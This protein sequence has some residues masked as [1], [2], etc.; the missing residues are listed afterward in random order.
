MA[1]LQKFTKN[2]VS[3]LLRHFDRTAN[4]ISNPDVNKKLTELNYNCAENQTLP[5][6]EFLQKRL[7]QVKI[8]NRKDVNLLCDWCLTA[9]QKLKENE[10]DIF[11]KKSYEFLENRYG[12][13]NVVSAWVHLDETTPHIHFAF[14]PVVEDKKKGGYKVSAKEVCH[15][16]DLKSFHSDLNKHLT[17]VFGRDIGVVNGA[18]VEGNKTKKELQQQEIAKLDKQ[19]LNTET[20]LMRVRQNV[21]IAEYELQSQESTLKQNQSKL[22]SQE[23]TLKQ[24]QSKLQSQESTLKQNQSKLQ[25]QESTL[26]QNQSKLQSQESTLEQKENLLN[27]VNEKLKNV[28][29]QKEKI[30]AISQIES[31]QVWTDK[32]KVSISVEDLHYLKKMAHKGVMGFE[33]VD[34]LK[35]QVGKLQEQVGTL[36]AENKKLNVSTVGIIKDKKKIYDL[37]KDVKHL[38]FEK[39]NLITFLEKQK[40]LEKFIEQDILDIKGNVKSLQSKSN[41]MQ[42]EM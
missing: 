37:E 36:Q 19:I 24:N 12:K 9:P 30:R 27:R 40:L 32:N 8:Q 39:N 17:A 23:S 35:E 7:S 31:K 34:I 29:I 5:A 14:I 13:E 22:Q 11:F 15:R 16:A 33:R 10:L 38:S 4:N 26:E 1:H 41:S 6:S 3:N 21:N 25:S 20:E 42:H 2:A 28:N 18:T